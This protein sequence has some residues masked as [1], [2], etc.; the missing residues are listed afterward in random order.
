MENQEAM[1]ELM[2]VT[3][4]N[5]TPECNSSPRYKNAARIEELATIKA[6]ENEYDT[7]VFTMAL[8]HLVDIGRRSLTKDAV[9][10][11]VHQIKSD[12][13]EGKQQPFLNTDFQIAI[14]RC[15]AKLSTMPLFS[16]LDYMRRNHSHL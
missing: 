1:E 7:W 5:D 11:Y 4:E 3:E 2:E 15:A 8:S 6:I 12:V 9:E 13:K 10:A 16:L 14:V